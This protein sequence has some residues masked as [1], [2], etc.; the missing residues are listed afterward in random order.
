MSPVQRSFLLSAVERY[1]SLLI[2]FLST[3]VLARLLSPAEF[4]VYAVVSAVTTII[5]VSTQEFGGA[6]YIIQKTSLSD[7][8]IRTAFTITLLLSLAMGL[9]LWLLAGVLDARMQVAGLAEGVRIAALGFAVTPFSSIMI[10]LLRRDLKFG[11]LSLANLAGNVVTAATSIA[12]AMHGGG[13]MAPIWGAVAGSAA[14]TAALLMARRDFRFM[15]PSL[16]GCREV[17]HFGLVSSGVALINLAYNTAPQVFLARVLGFAAVGL[18]SR[19]LTLTQMF[20]R[21]V[22]Q[23][24]NP[25][26]MP[27]FAAQTRAG[28]DLK[29]VYLK[30]ASLLAAL[31]WPFLLSVA[32]L[33]EPII[34]LWLGPTWMEA[35]P[36]VRWLCLGSLA[37]F[38]A[39][40][41]YPVLVATG[42]VRDALTSSLI[43]LPPSLAMIFAASFWGVQA[44]AIASLA[45]LPFQAA[46]AIAFI[47]R[48]LRFG[49]RDVARAL[50]KSAAVAFCCACA[51]G[52]GAAAIDAGW[53]DPL[54]GLAVSGALIVAA[55]IGAL[56]A[57]DHP[58]LAELKSGAGSVF[59]RA[60]PAAALPR[61]D[62]C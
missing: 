40:L 18:Y 8:N 6:N 32:I 23:A 4:G 13:A 58:L 15:K 50:R 60:A 52:I 7:A 30:S 27:A 35:A 36:L 28:G 39:C 25:V 17:I 37:L 38:A 51:A 43:S 14:L 33:A 54:P 44:V 56:A 19:A 24:I 45:T 49:P 2:L 9:G 22:V 61:R 20:D 62:L 21:L 42:R 1:A 3:A 55:W 34:R 53:L 48:R 57:T 31:Q 41:S 10:A 11:A 12:L 5:S 46:V 47:G 16:A 59:P 29:Q 26:I